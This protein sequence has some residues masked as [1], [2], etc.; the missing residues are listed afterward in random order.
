[1]AG[2][3]LAVGRVASRPTDLVLLGTTVGAVVAIPA[4]LIQGASWADGG[5]I[6]LG[7]YIGIGEVAVGWG[8]WTFAMAHPAGPRL[9]PLGYAT[10]LLSTLILLATGPRLST[11]A[12][13]GCALIVLC[14]IGV[15]M[16]RYDRRDKPHI[17]HRPLT[18]TRLN[19]RMLPWRPID[20]V[21]LP[22]L[23]HMPNSEGVPRR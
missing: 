20:Q 15:T 19:P 10:P 23:S 9:A 16:K 4:A 7:L 17:P 21:W 2:Y 14:A 6:A 3:T 12:L 5:A 13:V 22:G 1:M 8:L 18:R 11:I